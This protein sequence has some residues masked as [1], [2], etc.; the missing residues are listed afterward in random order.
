MRGSWI[1]EGELDMYGENTRQRRLRLRTVIDGTYM[2]QNQ[3]LATRGSK[4]QN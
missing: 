2:T 4:R 1:M 3:I